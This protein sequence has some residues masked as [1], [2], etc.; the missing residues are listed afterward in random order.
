V[1]DDGSIFVTR[2]GLELA[3]SPSDP[4]ASSLMIRP[5]SISVLEATASG[6]NV[7]PATVEVVTYLGSTSELILRLTSEETVM[8]S[9]PSGPG[10]DAPR[11]FTAGQRLC[12]RIDPASAVGIVPT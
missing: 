10:A 8:V 3:C 11:H 7:L 6:P 1:D 9:Q 4:D 12:I 2:S 5:E